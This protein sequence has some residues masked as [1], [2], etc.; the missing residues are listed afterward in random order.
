[1]NS[2]SHGH[3]TYQHDYH[4]MFDLPSRRSKSVDV[5]VRIIGRKVKKSYNGCSATCNYARRF[6]S[7]YMVDIYE[8][9]SLCS[10]FT[11]SQDTKS[12]CENAK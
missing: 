9:I 4:D 6:I 8:I 3:V 11:I 2:R 5:T 1:M 7:R 12:M 10:I